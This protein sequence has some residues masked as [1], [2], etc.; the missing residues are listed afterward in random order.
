MQLLRLKLYKHT[1]GTDT[2]TGQSE[3]VILQTNLTGDL[4]E[5]DMVNRLHAT[6]SILCLVLWFIRWLRNVYDRLGCKYGGI[7]GCK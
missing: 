5:V 2:W 6:V 4:I 3:L 1:A 7:F